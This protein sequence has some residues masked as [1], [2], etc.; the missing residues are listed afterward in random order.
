MESEVDTMSESDVDATAA[1][2]DLRASSL[3]EVGGG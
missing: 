3:H 2:I 1:E